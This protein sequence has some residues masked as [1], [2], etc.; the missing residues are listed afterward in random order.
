MQTREFNPW[1][2]Q[3]GY[4]F[5]QARE[6]TGVTRMVTLSGQCATDSNGAPQHPGDMAAQLRLTMQNFGTVL[7]AAGLGF[8]NVAG[9]RVYTTDMDAAMANWGELIAP[10]AAV[11]HS[12]ASTLIGVTRLFSPDIMIEI[13]ATACA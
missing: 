13:E 11:G 9:M 1:I 12:P 7:A 2:W 3:E 10:F 4:G 6:F 8:A 5:A